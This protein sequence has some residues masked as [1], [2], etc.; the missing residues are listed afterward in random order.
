MP[1][2][3]LSRLLIVLLLAVLATSCGGKV[4]KEFPPTP[5]VVPTPADV[6]ALTYE[7][8]VEKWLSDWKD[9]AF[10]SLDRDYV[11]CAGPDD[12]PIPP[13]TPDPSGHSRARIPCSNAIAAIDKALPQYRSLVDQLHDLGGDRSSDARVR[14]AQAALLDLNTKRLAFYEEAADAS[15]HGDEKRV[16]A[17]RVRYQDLATLDLT[18]V[19]A[20]QALSAPPK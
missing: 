15:H 18:S 7:T 13:T 3:R 10:P 1:I 17:L 16:A 8:K 14:A 20:I 11:N 12:P 6:D 19:R 5:T 4:I 2:P 9:A